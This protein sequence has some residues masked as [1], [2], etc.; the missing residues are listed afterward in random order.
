MLVVTIV[1]VGVIHVG[2]ALRQKKD[3]QCTYNVVVRRVRA[4]IL[5]VEKQ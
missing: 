2:Y 4:A 3:R 1:I 5:A